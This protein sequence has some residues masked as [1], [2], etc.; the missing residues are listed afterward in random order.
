MSWLYDPWLL[1]IDRD[2]HLL[3]IHCLYQRFCVRYLTSDAYSDHGKLP[4][5]TR[6]D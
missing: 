6:L 4:P 1:I 5:T 2:A 3:A